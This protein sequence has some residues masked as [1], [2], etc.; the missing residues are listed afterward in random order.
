MKD[1]RG[2]SIVVIGAARQ[3]LALARYFI[4]HGAHVI[5]NDQRSWEAL[6]EARSSLAD[7][8]ASGDGLEWVCGGHPLSVLENADLVC[9]S[10]GVPLTLPLILE[11]QA[12]GIP[13]TNDSQ[14]FLELAPCKVVGITGSA[15]KTT[16]TTLVGRMAQAAVQPSN[17]PGKASGD[18]PEKASGDAP[19]VYRKAWVGGNIGSPLI[20]HVDEMDAQ[21]LAIMELSSFQLEIMTRSPQVAAVLNVTPNHLDRHV[22][23]QAYLAAKSRILAFQGDHDIAVLGRDE[24]NAWTLRSMLRGGLLS[25]GFQKLPAGESGVW[26]DEDQIMLRTSGGDDLPLM[27][28]QNIELRGGHNV[29]NVMAACAIAAAAGLPASAMRAGVLGFGGVPHRLEYI[30]TWGGA[31]WYND[32]IATAPERAMAAVRSFDEP[33]VLLAGGRDKKLP[34]HEFAELV[35]RRVRCLVVFGEAS[36]IILQALD[37][38]TGKP[39]VVIHCSTLSEAVLAAAE[40]ARPGEVVLLSPGGTS[41]D[42]FSDFEERGRCFAQWVKDLP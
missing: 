1:W 22:T 25:F 36:D 23:M 21:D 28:V 11:A 37:G 35:H 13:L 5:L 16:T 2:Q 33:L 32:S 29:Q 38:A 26:L 41:F 24:A 10:G 6:Q 15:G 8:P 7:L 31:K 3:G 19:G 39:E 30:R 27:R 40:H 18:T 20:A 9:I 4:S 12:R 42:E 34:W 14:V 17:A